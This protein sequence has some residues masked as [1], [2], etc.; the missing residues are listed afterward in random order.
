MVMR[1]CN[2][3]HEPIVS[4]ALAIL[5]NS[6]SVAHAVQRDA[7]RIR[8]ACRPYRECIAGLPQQRFGRA[9]IRKSPQDFNDAHG[10]ARI[11]RQRP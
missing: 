4:C 3:K 6:G 5:S 7:L 1:V 11:A 2:A 10:E 8:I 9:V